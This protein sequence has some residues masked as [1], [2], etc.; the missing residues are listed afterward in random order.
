MTTVTD[1]FHDNNSGD[2]SDFDKGDLR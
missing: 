1:D 2:A